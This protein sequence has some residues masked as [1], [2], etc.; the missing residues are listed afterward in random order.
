MYLLDTNVISEL[1]KE[2]SGKAHP[3]VVQWARSVPSPALY[4]SVI[5][6]QELEIGVQLAQRRHH[7]ESELLRHWLNTQVLPSF[8][9]R[10]LPIT[11]EI[12]LHSAGLHVPDPRPVRDTFIAATAHVHGLTVVTRNIADFAPS[13][14]K[15]LNPWE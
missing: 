8:Q 11:L 12:A 5:T 3:G 6:A 14:V 4:L 9:G 15:V 10:I 1:R 7:P 13:G 2:R